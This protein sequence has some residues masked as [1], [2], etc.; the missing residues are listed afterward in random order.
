MF[1]MA[2]LGDFLGW[3]LS[4][5]QVVLPKSDSLD[6]F[7]LASLDFSENSRSSQEIVL[8]E[9]REISSNMLSCRLC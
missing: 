1:F 7:S 2:D 3:F 9:K 4:A 8:Y 6:V 5:Q